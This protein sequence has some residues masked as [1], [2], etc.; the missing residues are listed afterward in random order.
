[1]LKPHSLGYFACA[2]A[3]SLLELLIS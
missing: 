1:L 3:P 2:K